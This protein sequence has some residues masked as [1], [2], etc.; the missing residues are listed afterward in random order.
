NPIIVSGNHGRK[1]AEAVYPRGR[2]YAYV[3]PTN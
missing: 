2:V 3:M 1:V